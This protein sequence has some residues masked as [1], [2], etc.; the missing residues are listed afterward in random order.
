MDIKR[1]TDFVDEVFGIYGAADESL[2]ALQAMKYM[3]TI[4]IT[5]AIRIW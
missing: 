2:F 1:D 5:I 4:V 3:I